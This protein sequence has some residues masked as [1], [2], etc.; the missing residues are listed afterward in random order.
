M[1]PL[2]FR[3]A[4]RGPGD[5]AWPGERWHRVGRAHTAPGAA[6]GGADRLSLEQ[7]LLQGRAFVCFVLWA[8][9]GLEQHLAPSRH[10]GAA[11]GRNG[12]QHLGMSSPDEE[13]ALDGAFGGPCRTTSPSAGASWVQSGNIRLGVCS[14]LC[15]RMVT[16]IEARALCSIGRTDRTTGVK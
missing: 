11:W 15:R 8:I 3:I 4:S 9:P 13:V 16:A 14:R 1:A 2:S 10:P 6:E 12:P 5:P 7:R